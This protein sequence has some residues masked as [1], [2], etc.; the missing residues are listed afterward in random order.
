MTAAAPT[1][2]RRDLAA[3]LKAIHAHRHRALHTAF[4]G[5][6]DAELR[7][8]RVL[9]VPVGGSEVRFL[10]TE[11]ES[12]LA[13]RRALA[14]VEPGDGLALLLSYGDRVPF[15]VEARLARGGVRHVDRGR[16]LAARFEARQVSPD[17]L[18]NRP[19]VEALLDLERAFPPAPG[20]SLDLDT[21]WRALL[22]AVTPLGATPLNEGALLAFA[23]RAGGGPDVLQ[24]LA[25]WPEL[26]A[27]LH[28]WLAKVA[29]PVARLAWRAWEAGEGVRA[30]ALTFVLQSCAPAIARG[31]HGYVRGLLT[32]LLPGLDPELAGAVGNGALLERWGEIADRLA[33]ALED[34]PQTLAAVLREADALLPAEGEV[35][36]VLASSRHLPRALATARSALARALSAAVATGGAAAVREAMA[37]EERYAAHRLAG[38]VAERAG[39]ERALMALRLLVWRERRPREDAALARPPAEVAPA[40]AARFAAEGGFVDRARQAL[41]GPGTDELGQALASVLAMADALRD[42]DDE[43]FARALPDWISRGRPQGDALPIE[44]VLEASA[45][46]FLE[47]GPRRRL[48]I[49]L[50]D[51]MSWE[52]AVELVLD[53]ETQ[54]FGP[55]ADHLALRLGRPVLAA[56][57]TLTEVSRSALF[58]GKLVKPGEVRS[59]SGDV[60]RFAGHRGFARLGLT[61]KLLLG[62][63]AVGRDGAATREAL[64]LVRSADRVVGVVLNAIDDALAQAGHLRTI[65]TLESIPALRDLL[66]E[67][68]F[69]GRALLLVADHGHVQGARFGAPVGAGDGGTRWRKLATGEAPRA[70]EVELGGPGVWRPPG[71][72]RVALLYAETDCYGSGPREGEHG[73]AALAEVVA[74]ALLVA[75]EQLVRDA[76][77]EGAPDPG[78]AVG[79]LQRPAFWELELPPPG[80]GAGAPGPRGEGVAAPQ[81]RGRARRVEDDATLPL[82]AVLTARPAF[83]GRAAAALGGGT[84]AGATAE[85]GPAVGGGSTVTPAG[86]AA[87]DGGRSPIVALLAASQLLASM[88]AARPRVKQEAVLRAVEIL[89]A[90]GGQL[91]PELFAT[92]Y[93]VLPGR[94]GGLVAL[95]GEVLNVEGYPVLTLDRAVGL[96]RLDEARLQGLFGV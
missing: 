84:G 37:A 53:L 58:A 73:G 12:E 95:L 54:G 38:S 96:V 91:A 69:A 14:T 76:D 44:E 32:A 21:A 63:S 89:H 46:K 60:E 79:P 87:Q 45:V 8:D 35:D 71:V 28:T 10:V 19:L 59:A 15:D 61:P 94:L 65:L 75:S 50:M 74:P 93:G 30:A 66:R 33:L 23:A 78:L 49:A 13:L 64:D 3:E 22:G 39:R 57:P 80:A 51:G 25:R 7:G 72:D 47:K 70:R 18:L 43:R 55:C 77:A 20:M 16:R 11:V 31:E 88:L 34:A 24:H 6:A 83:G 48:L 17:V 92:R 9:K 62:G 52:R 27:R 81:R 42:A 90:A 36:A 41:R 68:S 40:V 26:R 29:G 1:L 85:A 82:P 86:A 56:L 4:H 5:L 67:A 2:T